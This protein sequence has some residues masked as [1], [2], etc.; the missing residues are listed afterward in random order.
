MAGPGSAPYRTASF[1]DA[2]FGQ[3]WDALAIEGGGADL[4]GGTNEFATIYRAA[5]YGARPP[6][7]RS[8]RRT[9]PAAGPAPG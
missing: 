8:P 1:N 6:R 2:V 9:T 5:A 3:S 7:S 4:W